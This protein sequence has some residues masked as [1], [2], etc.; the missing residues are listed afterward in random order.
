[1]FK[2]YGNTKTKMKDKTSNEIGIILLM[3]VDDIENKKNYDLIASSSAG[4]EEARASMKIKAIER[5]QFRIKAL[6]QDTEEEKEVEDVCRIED[7]QDCK[8][9]A[10]ERLTSTTYCMACG[11]WAGH[12]TY[13]HPFKFICHCPCGSSYCKKSI[14]N[15]PR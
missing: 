11:D 6:L 9:I 3:L 7:C 15:H 1:M 8:Q 4:D 13:N 12:K 10:I 14:C 5:A 2:G